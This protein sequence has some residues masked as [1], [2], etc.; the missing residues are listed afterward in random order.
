MP[1][2]VHAAPGK[3]P[4]W[5]IPAAAVAGALI[6]GLLCTWGILW[7]MQ[8]RARQAATPPQRRHRHGRRRR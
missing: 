7:G 4:P 6:A 2:G 1:K 3:Q 5:L 8:R